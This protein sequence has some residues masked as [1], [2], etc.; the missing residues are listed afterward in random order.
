MC[1]CA[2]SGTCVR[3]KFLKV[4]NILSWDLTVSTKLVFKLTINLSSLLLSPGIK[5]YHQANYN[6]WR[7]FGLTACKVCN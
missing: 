7:T 2:M 5:G 3:V 4:R 6:F 1:V